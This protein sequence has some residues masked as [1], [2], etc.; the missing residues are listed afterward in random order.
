MVDAGAKLT[1]TTQRNTI[2][3]QRLAREHGIRNPH[4]VVS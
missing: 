3:T 1:A 4:T 2:D